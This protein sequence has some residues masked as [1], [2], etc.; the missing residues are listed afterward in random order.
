MP[1]LQQDRRGGSSV[2]TRERIRH[3]ARAVG[4][5]RLVAVVLEHRAVALKEIV[6]FIQYRFASLHACL[7]SGPGSLWRTVSAGGG[8]CQF[9]RRRDRAGR[10]DAPEGRR[11]ATALMRSTLSRS[12]SASPAAVRSRARPVRQGR[13]FEATRGQACASLLMS[14]HQTRRGGLVPIVS[15]EDGARP[16]GRRGPCSSGH[17][18]AVRRHP[19]SGHGT[20]AYHAAPHF[21]AGLSCLRAPRS[22]R[23][24]AG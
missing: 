11:G 1:T 9:P 16:Q 18:C 5:I 24:I 3:D 6:V 7:L 23:R 17:R 8:Y 14:G 22:C 19:R 13:T 2:G 10:H 12:D 20:R 15:R 21:A 4:P